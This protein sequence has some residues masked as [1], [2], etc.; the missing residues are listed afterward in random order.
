M[1]KCTTQRFGDWILAPSS[2]R[3]QLSRSY[4]KTE[5]KSSPKRCFFNKQD[6]VSDKDNNAENVQ[7]H[8][9]YTNVP[10]SQ[11]FRSYLY[12]V[13]PPIE[14]LIVSLSI[15]PCLLWIHKFNY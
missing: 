15:Y 10:S 7:K 3:T 1:N 6:G 14:D 11:P 4:L 12:R 5:T 8:N 13:W 9:I 2:G